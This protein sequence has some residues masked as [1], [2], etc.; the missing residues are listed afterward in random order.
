M[1]VTCVANLWE[2]RSSRSVQFTSLYSHCSVVVLTLHVNVCPCQVTEHLAARHRI[3]ASCSEV[4]AI[5]LFTSD[6]ARS[7]VWVILK[8]MESKRQTMEK[9]R[10][11]MD[12]A[13]K[14]ATML[15]FL[16]DNVVLQHEEEKKKNV[17]LAQAVAQKD[18]EL[19]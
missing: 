3:G 15:M 14:H 4:L 5:N 8:E 6:Q 7:E 11:R 10:A 12:E 9:M 13:E 16:N 2:T 18:Q 1:F 17:K 19:K